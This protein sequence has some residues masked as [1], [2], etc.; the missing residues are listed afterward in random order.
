MTQSESEND[1]RP[2]IPGDKDYLKQVAGTIRETNVASDI[3]FGLLTEALQV[4]DIDVNP[5]TL[6]T[7]DN[8]APENLKTIVEQSYTKVEEKA[9][10]PM[11]RQAVVGLW[12]YLAA[13]DELEPAE[14]A[15]VFGGPN[16]QR[17][18]IAID[19]Y[20][21]K[22]VSK[23]LF[24]GSH[25]SYMAVPELSEAAMYRQMAVRAGVP[26]EAI[27]IEEEARNTP[28]NA[29]KSAAL[30]RSL[31]YEPKS[32]IAITL[33]YHMLRSSLTLAA[34]TE[35]WSPKIIRKVAPS[36]KFTEDN[37]YKDPNGWAYVFNEYIKLYGARLMKHF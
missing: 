20:D 21:D 7:L 28:E 30:L 11:V 12:H 26:S 2:H 16:P 36:A 24:S 14:L 5:Y 37:F 9:D 3:N 25:A 18:Q 32:I 4:L 17:A 35:A 10:D 19:L 33:P 31:N 6:V 22:L 23:I 15:F 13:E 29:A 8:L 34:A 27:I 1:Y